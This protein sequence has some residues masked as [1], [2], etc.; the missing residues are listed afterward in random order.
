MVASGAVAGGM[1]PKAEACCRRGAGRGAAG[2]RPR[3]A[4][5]PR[6]AARA[7]HRRRRGHHGD[8]VTGVGPP[9]PGEPP[10]VRLMGTYAEPPVTFVR[11]EGAVPLRRRGPALPRL[12]LRA[13]RHLARPRPPGGGRGAWPPRPPPCATCPTSTAT[14]WP[15]RWP[16]PSTG[17]SVAADPGRRAGLLLQLG[18][19]GQRVRPQAGPQVGRPAA[20][21]GGVDLDDSFH[22]RTLATLAATGQPAK[23]VPFEPLPDGFTHVPYDDL[24]ALDAALD[25]A[26]VGRRP[27]RAH[28]GGG[29]RGAALVGLP[30]RRAAG[31]APSTGRC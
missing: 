17:W 18:G 4:G 24:G 31:C 27:A 29:R 6:P 11:G 30:G 20:P 2:P 21:R 14:S 12:R 26:P 15:P 9:R 28:P 23:H 13:G 19:R 10:T 25:P 1:V 3:R 5:A 22:G 8:A 16:P 7:V